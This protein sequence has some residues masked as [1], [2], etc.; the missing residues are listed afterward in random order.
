MPVVAPI[1]E[2]EVELEPLT[3]GNVMKALDEI[4]LIEVKGRVRT[5]NTILFHKS[6]MKIQLPRSLCS[7]KKLN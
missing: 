4:A 7:N 1:A 6:N 5:K 3:V 2:P